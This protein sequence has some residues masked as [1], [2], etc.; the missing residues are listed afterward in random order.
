MCYK[1]NF[2]EKRDLVAKDGTFFQGRESFYG[3][4][5]L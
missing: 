5:L 3:K 2:V 4:K 1:K